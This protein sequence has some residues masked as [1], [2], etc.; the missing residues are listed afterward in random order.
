MELFP[1]IDDAHYWHWWAFGIILAML[2][3]LIPGTFLLWMGVSAGVVGVILL[4]APDMGWQGQWSIFAVLSVAAVVAARL[5][6]R[7]NPIET[8]E[9]ALNR[10]GQQYVGRTFTLAE[11]IVNGSGSLRIDDTRWKI[12]GA[13]APAG[14][15]IRVTGTEGTELVVERTEQSRAASPPPKH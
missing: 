13:D 5:F 1:F 15:Q 8:D 10:R 9:P 12:K 11:P 2:E 6:I 7:R 14:A 3:M 4:A